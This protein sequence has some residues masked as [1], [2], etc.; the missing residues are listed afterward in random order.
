MRWYRS[1]TEKGSAQFIRAKVRE[2]RDLA[3]TSD[4]FVRAQGAAEGWNAGRI[5]FPAE[6]SPLY[7]EWVD[8]SLDEIAA[9]TGVKD[10]HDDIV[11]ALAAGWDELNPK[12]GTRSVSVPGGPDRHDRTVY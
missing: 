2:F 11:D 10:A 9:F 6:D 7:G 8:I 3:T 4:K 5:A 1:G 12:R